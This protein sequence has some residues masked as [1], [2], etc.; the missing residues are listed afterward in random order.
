MLMDNSQDAPALQ[1]HSRN[2]LW[3]AEGAAENA[4]EIRTLLVRCARDRRCVPDRQQYKLWLRQR[5][6]KGEYPLTVAY[7]ILLYNS[8]EL[9]LYDAGLVASP[10]AIQPRSSLDMSL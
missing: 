8:W 2:P 10:D 1:P 4:A 9:A 3:L 5:N 7:I 6:R